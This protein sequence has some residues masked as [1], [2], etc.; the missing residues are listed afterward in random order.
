[1]GECFSQDGITWAPCQCSCG[2]QTDLSLT[3]LR[4]G[5]SKCCRSCAGRATPKFSS[6]KE[7]NPPS[8]EYRSWV[9]MKSRC[10]NP[11]DSS[12]KNYGER[13][14]KVCDQ[15]LGP[16]GYVTFLHDMGRRPFPKHSL[17]RRDNNGDYTP[18][19]CFWSAAKDQA[20]NRRGNHVLTH[21]GLTMTVSEWSDATCLPYSTLTKRL[22]YGWSTE[23][24]LTERRR[25][26]ARQGGLVS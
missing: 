16:D 6:H 26:Y 25:N 12:W 15:W 4:H 5:K 23:R 1:M 19:N 10:S 14:I 11:N 18:D 22:K 9:S 13:G 24:T 7:S 3:R 21:N 17:E 20:R 8:L 2:A